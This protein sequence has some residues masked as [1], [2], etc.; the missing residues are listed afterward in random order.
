MRVPANLVSNLKLEK[1]AEEVTSVPLD[2]SPLLVVDAC[3][4]AA[5]NT[6]AEFARS[7]FVGGRR[8]FSENITMP[9]KTFG[10]RPITITGPVDRTLYTALVTSISSALGSESRDRDH[11][12]AHEQMGLQP[13]VPDYVV[14][15][16]VASFYEYVDHALLH[17]RLLMLTMKAD[18]SRA[19][20]D[21]LGEAFDARIGLPQMQSSSDLLADAYI[22]PVSQ[23]LAL[24]G[25]ESSRYADDFKVIAKDWGEAGLAIETIVEETRRLGLVLSTEKTAIWKSATLVKGEHARRATLDRYFSRARDALDFEMVEPAYSAEDESNDLPPSALYD[26]A[27]RSILEEWLAGD[28]DVRAGLDPFIS[29]A[30]R[31]LRRASGRL[32]DDLLFNLVYRHPTRM[33][34]VAKYIL[35]RPDTEGKYNWKTI[36]RLRSLDLRSPWSR[37][38]LLHLIG[39]LPRKARRIR[40]QVESFAWIRSQLSDPREVVRAEA[41]WT[42]AAHRELREEE[43][44]ALLSGGSDLSRPAVVASLARQQESENTTLGT[45]IDKSTPLTAAAARWGAAVA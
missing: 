34:D 26:S 17:D 5:P 27:N 8:V 11:W 31:T 22:E 3:L 20:V 30:L 21:W 13:G 33:E 9:R 25:F 35:S 44:R 7:N 40:S 18:A 14:K 32:S 2:R 24:A 1:A 10:S 23:S 28:D 19:I 6:V 37:L 45:A 42:L 12:A 38:W 4:A 16:D 36:Q 39:R 41:A 43:A 15:A 29:S